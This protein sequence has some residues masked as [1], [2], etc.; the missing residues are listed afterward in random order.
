VTTKDQLYW[1]KLILTPG[2][3]P[4]GIE[5]LRNYFGDIESIFQASK[6]QLFAAGLSPDIGNTF[7]EIDEDRLQLASNW[8]ESSDTHHLLCIDD[9]EYPAL[10]KTIHDAPPVLFV[11]GDVSLLS[12]LQLA[13]VAA[14]TQPAVAAR[15]PIV[16]PAI[17]LN[18]ALL[19]P[20]A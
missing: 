2:L 11:S 16:F 10:L 12:Q 18:Q 14:A 6:S 7:T 1:L 5:K 4:A 13:I 3:G 9:A 17:W 15:P 20:V 8:L 19:L